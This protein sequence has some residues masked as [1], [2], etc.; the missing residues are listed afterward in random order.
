MKI[1]KIKGIALILTAAVLPT[2]SNAATIASD[3]NIKLAPSSAGMAGAGYVRP[4]DSAASVFGNPASLTQLDGDTGFTFGATFV[5]VF[6]ETT[7]D[8]SLVPAFSGDIEFE[9]YLLPSIAFRQRITDKLVIGSGLQ[10]ISG[11]GSDFRSS[12]VVQPTVTYITFGANLAAAYQLTDKTSVGASVTTAY[13]LLELGLVSNTA[14]QETF[15]FRGG[16]GINHDFGPI[17]AG[18]NYNSELSLDFDNVVRTAPG[19]MSDFEL[20]Q[21]REIIIGVAST[22]ALWRKLLVEANFIYKNWDN[23]KGY[24]DIWQDTYT[25][26]FGTQYSLT[27]RLKLRAGYSYTS[28]ILKKNGLGNSISGLTSLELGGAAVPVS[29]QLLQFMQATLADPAWN[30]NITLG[31]GYNFTDSIR[32]DAHAGYAFGRDRTLGANRIE[33]GLYNIGAGISWNF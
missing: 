18:L 14:I 12:S 23:A 31:A 4:Q 7:H 24:Q 28:D 30:N 9:Y 25:F 6:N 19:R 8:G 22:D 11:L 3:T 20:E 10:V 1:N 16:L 21:P 29:P 17:M 13:S 33:V 2:T 27:D 15:G 5:E 32:L 26:Q